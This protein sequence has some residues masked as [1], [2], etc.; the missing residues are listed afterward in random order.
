MVAEGTCTF[1]IQAWDLVGNTAQRSGMVKVIL[2][3][4]AITNISVLPNPISPNGDGINDGGVGFGDRLRLGDGGG[5]WT[6]W[7][8]W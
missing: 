4:P 1:T 3:P 2:T 7:G 8:R 6:T 5:C